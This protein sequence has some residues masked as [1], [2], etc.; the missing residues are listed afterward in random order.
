MLGHARTR[1]DSFFVHHGHYVQA[2]TNSTDNSYNIPKHHGT[3]WHGRSEGALALC[4]RL[5]L[6][7][8]SR[9][10]TSS[11]F[12]STYGYLTIHVLLY[13]EIEFQ[14]GAPHQPCQAVQKPKLCIPTMEKLTNRIKLGAWLNR[15]DSEVASTSSTS[16]LCGAFFP[17][18]LVALPASTDVPFQIGVL[19]GCGRERW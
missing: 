16:S 4:L 6:L 5:C 7:V 14:I 1:S 3:N 17:T 9:K 10:S 18:F 15:L 2:R 19:G 11:L 13:V 12:W 8:V